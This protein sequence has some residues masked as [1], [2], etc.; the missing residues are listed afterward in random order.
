MNGVRLISDRCFRYLGLA[1]FAGLFC[2]GSAHATVTQPDGKVVPI[3][4]RAA[5]NEKQVYDAFKPEDK[6]AMLRF[7]EDANTAP[8]VFSPLCSFT[9]E[10]LLKETGS[11]LAV[12][13]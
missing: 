12:G 1:A 5:T 3:D 13:W 8:E 9:A 11:D 10:L 7:R 4:S 6:T 2:A